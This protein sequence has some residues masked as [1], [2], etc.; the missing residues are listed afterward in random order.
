MR[1]RKILVSVGGALALVT[2]G[3]GGGSSGATPAASSQAPSSASPAATTSTDAAAGPVKV[4]FITKF[5]VAFFTAMDDAA[6]A[7]SEQNPGVADISYFSCKSPSDVPCQTAQIE[8]AVAKGFQAIVITPMGPEVVPAMNAA[9]DKGLKVILVDN[10][11]EAFTK[12]TA[13]AATDNVK[14]GEAA[15]AYLK[16]VLKSGDTIGLMEGVRGVPALDARIQG[17]KD[18]LEGT[19]VKVII[20]GAETKCDAAKGATVAQDLLTRAPKLTAIYSACDDPAI[21]AAKVAKQKGKKVLVMGYD[22]LPDAA[23]A[24]Q[25]GDMRATIAQFPG[26]MASL[27]VEAAVN[28]V[29]GK[30]VEA[31][32]D[33]GTALVTTDNAADFLKFQ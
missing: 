14:G 19:G 18:A 27:G 2:A 6:K 1:S 17:V 23:K 13:V 25:A 21:A 3:C 7:W 30:P 10:N 24:I 26:K 15:G 29:Q 33:T 31:F 20:G 11:L 8:D 28:A 32:I 16:S 22:G 9:A 4:A 5:P 12:R